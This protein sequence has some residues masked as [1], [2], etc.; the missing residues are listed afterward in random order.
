M[1]KVVFFNGMNQHIADIFTEMSPKGFEV[2]CHPGSLSEEDKLEIIQDAEF[3][4]LHPATVSGKILRAGQSLR[5]IQILSAG[6][7]KV[8]MNTAK[9]LNIP[10]AT[11]GGANAYAVAEH[12]VALLLALYKKLIPCDRSV[13]AG[14]WREAVTGFDT[15]ELAGKTI[16]IIGAGK[17]GRKVARRLEA[18]ET[19]ILYYDPYPASDI[20]KE[21]NAR[22][23]TLD[24]LLMKSDVIT[25]H[26]PLLKET[27]GLISGR[28]FSLL[29]PTAVFINTSRAEI[30]DENALLSA[31]KEKK[32]AG[33]G[34][35]VFHKEP[36]SP[37]DPLLKFENVIVTPHTA[38]HA[39]EGWMRRIRFAWENIERVASGQ[40][41]AALVRFD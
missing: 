25:L 9:E 31:L 2:S 3:L 5:L 18:F 30:V 14:K 34:L 4:V 29:K 13:R 6:Y 1:R 38:G 17:I 35:D 24:E 32:I 15:F 39:C 7:D 37:D 26:L 21:L 28:E 22:R 33:A 27:R 11:N 8:D 16:G 40:M 20:E 36:I 23:A 10:V 41:P 19:E 12:T